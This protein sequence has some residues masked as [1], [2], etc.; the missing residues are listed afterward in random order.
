M[1][2]ARRRRHG[3]AC[4]RLNKLEGKMA[5]KEVKLIL[6]AACAPQKLDPDWSDLVAQLSLSCCG[7]MSA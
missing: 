6:R 2:F 7:M 4:R 1:N 5:A 3:Y